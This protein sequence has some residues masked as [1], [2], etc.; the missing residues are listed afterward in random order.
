MS[1]QSG[2]RVVQTRQLAAIMFTDIV[3]YTALTERDESGAITVRDRHRAI[4]RPLVEQFEGELVETPGDESLAAFPSALLAVDCALA[5]QAALRDDRD[6]RL[7][8]GI[9]LG[10]VVRREGEIIG[11]GVNVAARIR[12]LARPGGICVSEAVYRMVRNHPHVRGQSLGPQALRN[13]DGRIEVF[14]LE[15]ASGSVRPRSRGALKV[16]GGIVA[17][18]VLS[19]GVYL[20]NRAA[21]LSS[22]AINAPLLFTDPIEQKLGFATTSDGTRIAYATTGE[23][24][25]LVFV[26]GWATHLERGIGSPIYDNTGWVRAISRD[27]LFVRY[28][29]RGFGLS[30]RDV[31]DF[32]L[33]ARVRDL[34]AV[35]DALRLDRFAIYAV[36]AGGPTGIAYAARHPERVS[37]L[38]FVGT[39]TTFSLDADGRE[40]WDGMLKLYRTS[41]DSPV[42]RSMMITWLDPDADEITQRVVS[43]FLRVSGDGP[44]VS[45]F[46]REFWQIDASDAARSLRV[47]TLV[48][49]GQNDSPVPLRWGRDL[50]SLIPGARFEI[51]QGADH[52]EATMGSP[53]I[54]K[55]IAEFLES[56]PAG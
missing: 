29:G 23:G 47:P 42:V 39:G 52:F 28:D 33:D 43:E 22:V 54:P 49:H 41:W 2:P 37:A 9:H 24:S 26:L 5:L 3:G 44:A 36:S 53:R 56:V 12:P 40:Q 30:D 20:P 11:D 38:V 31:E 8:V 45:G 32:S 50:A 27:H 1:E 34:E 4:V 51:L 14:A 35:V 19:Y 55:L 21:I 25:P 46:F 7:R 48:I 10:D 18:A 15:T 13:V 16:A 6:L 17:M